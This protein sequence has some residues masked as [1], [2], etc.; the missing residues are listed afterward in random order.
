MSESYYRYHVFFCTWQREGE[1]CCQQYDAQAMC[2][3]AKK[4]VKEL[5]LSAPGQVRVNS[6]GCLNRCDR[7]PVIVVYP[8]AVWYTWADKKDID[9]IIEQ[10][11][12]H[13][14]VVERLKI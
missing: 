6:T 7:G 12:R 10:H 3:Y 13:G 2:G 9:E 14:K 1:Q 11:L 8:E 4:R 5:G